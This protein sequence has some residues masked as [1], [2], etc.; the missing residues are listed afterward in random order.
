MDVATGR[1]AA[2][3]D[4]RAHHIKDYFADYG[5]V[6]PDVMPQVEYRFAPNDDRGYAPLDR[7][8]NRF[9]PTEYLDRPGDLPSE[10]DGITLGDAAMLKEL[11]PSIYKVI[12]SMVGAVD[13]ELE[14]FINWFAYIVQKRTKTGTAYILHGTSGTGKGLFHT[15]IAAPLLG[16][17]YVFNLSLSNLLDMSNL[18]A[19]TSLLVLIDEFRMGDFTQES[20]INNTLKRL[21]TEDRI[22]IRAMRKDFV[23]MDTF[24]SFIFAS[25]DT[26]LIEIPEG[27]RRFNVCPAQQTKLFTRYPELRFDPTAKLDKELP[28]FAAFLDTWRIDEQAATSV[29]ETE[30]KD[31]LRQSAM[32]THDTFLQAVRLG[33]L[34]YFMDFLHEQP[35]TDKEI[36]LKI[37]YDNI[38]K[39]AVQTVGITKASPAAAMIEE[40]LLPL[41]DLCIM[42]ARIFG[43]EVHARS[44]AKMLD[45]H[46][47]PSHRGRVSGT[48]RMHVKVPWSLAHY[49]YEDVVKTVLSDTEYNNLALRQLN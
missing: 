19:A 23:E 39:K 33:D 36:A 48:V 6:P 26:D 3:N 14:Y 11:C 22:S 17:K 24:T 41:T 15:H 7:F 45:R 1:V 8:V 47:I 27:D 13:E 34:D 30:A 46:R 4:L 10:Y 49:A 43:K 5:H 20:R 42:Y 16:K 31:R 40:H 38:M 37:P 44:M 32:K 18:W 28:A 9:S 21:I 2:V 25:N 29:R 35:I 12:F